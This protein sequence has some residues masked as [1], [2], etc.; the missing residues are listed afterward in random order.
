MRAGLGGMG[1]VIGRSMGCACFEPAQTSNQWT[2]EDQPAD[3]RR[4]T[5][6]DDNTR[7]AY[8]HPHDDQPP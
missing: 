1:R 4:Q 8:Q 6:L 5:G 7:V 3:G 2:R